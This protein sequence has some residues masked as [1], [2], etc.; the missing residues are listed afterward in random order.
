MGEICN[1]HYYKISAQEIRQRNSCSLSHFNLAMKKITEATKS[2]LDHNNINII[3]RL[4]T[5]NENDQLRVG[6]YNIQI[7]LQKTKHGHIWKT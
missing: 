5:N 7:S 1:L 3:Y 6:Q 2:K 4:I